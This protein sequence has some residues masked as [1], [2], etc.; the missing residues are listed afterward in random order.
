M[1]TC[2]SILVVEDDADHAD[3]IQQSLS[4]LP[5]YKF[6]FVHCSDSRRAVAAIKD[7]NPDVVFMDYQLGM[8]NG[9]DLLRQIRDSGDQRPIVVLTAHGNEYVAVEMMKAGADDYLVKADM[10]PRKLGQIVIE[11]MR[12]QRKTPYG[13]QNRG[14]ISPRLGKLTP[15]EREVLDL[16]VQGMTSREISRH[17][18][19]SENTIKIHRSRVMQ[20]M[21]ANTVADLVRM[22]LLFQS[23]GSVS[24]ISE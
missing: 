5:G 19:R 21:Q 8:D 16:I 17:L 23:P 7:R 9:L 12:R 15:R 2:A 10:T 3:L 1:E 4:K 22:V 6:D 13:E 20:K 24:S 18:H 14:V 11:A